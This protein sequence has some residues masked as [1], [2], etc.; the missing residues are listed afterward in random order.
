MEEIVPLARQFLLA[1]AVAVL[2]VK[3]QV[4]MEDRAAV[5]VDTAELVGPDQLARVMAAETA[6]MAAVMLPAAA[7]AAQVE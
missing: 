2:A 3:P 7:V 4:E 6:S 5:L 1:V